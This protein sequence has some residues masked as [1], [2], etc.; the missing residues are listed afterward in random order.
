MMS[1]P[2]RQLPP[3]Y[4]PPHERPNFAQDIADL[5]EP[6]A[7]GT[8]QQDMEEQMDQSGSHIS[9]SKVCSEGRSETHSETQSA[10]E[11]VA[12]EQVVFDHESEMPSERIN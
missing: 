3:D 4:I 9:P 1:P 8:G 12:L 5:Q 10:L 2:L 11:L 6:I 7:G